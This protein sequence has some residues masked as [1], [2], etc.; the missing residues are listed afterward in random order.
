MSSREVPGTGTE[1]TDSQIPPTNPQVFF[2]LLLF[3]LIRPLS[4]GGKQSNGELTAWLFWDQSL[5]ISPGGGKRLDEKPGTTRRGRTCVLAWPL[6]W[7]LRA[8]RP[9]VHVDS[10]CFTQRTRW[11]KMKKPTADL[12]PLQK[13]RSGKQDQGL[14]NGADSVSIRGGSIVRAWLLIERGVEEKEDEIW[15]PVMVWVAQWVTESVARMENKE[16]A[17]DRE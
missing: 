15:T 5:R 10:R 16:Q 4:R 13:C 7:S 9:G 3:I 12:R 2:L 1:Q 14:W 8:R 6:P 17:H 11:N